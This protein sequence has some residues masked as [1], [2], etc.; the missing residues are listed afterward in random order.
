MTVESA[1][2]QPAAD[3]VEALRAQLKE[4]DRLRRQNQR[5]VA[6]RVEPLAVVG[7]ACRLPGGVESPEDLWDLVRDGRDAISGFPQDRGWDLA[8]LI[9][10]GPGQSITGSGGFLGDVAG[11]DAEFFGIAP[12]EALAMDPQQ[13]ISLEVCWEAL[14]HAGIDPASLAG[15][16]TGVFVGASAGDYDA[17]SDGTEGYNLTGGSMAVVSG[18]LSYQLGLEGPAVTVDTACSSSL[19]ALH[20]AGQ[21]LRQGEC[22]LALVGGVAVLATPGVFV[23]FSRQGGLAPDGRCKSFSETADGTGWAEGAAMLV[24]ERLSD[25]ERNG[26]RVL[27]LVRGSA[28]NQDGA[29]NGLSAPN[30]PSQQRVIR[31]ALKRAGL[32]PSD[33]DVVEAHG[34]GTTLGDPIEAQ[35][36]LATYGQE[37]ERPVLVGSM[38]SNIGHTQA[39]SGL[40]GVIKMVQ[41]LRHGVAP[42]SLHLDQPSSHVD[43]SAGAVELLTG[44]SEWP[45]V[46][47]PRRAAV[48]AFG[49]SGTNAHVILEQG[50]APADHEPAEVPVVPW[51]VSATSE[52]ALATQVDRLRSRTEDRADVGW[53]LL[54]RS[55]FEHRSVLLA[56]EDGVAEVARGVAGE[57]E[58]AFLFS[59]QGSQRLGMGR[60]LYGR[61][62]VFAEAL[63]EVLDR[64]DPA[65]REV[66]WGSDQELLN[67]TGF[68]QPA[69]FAVEVALFRLV[70]SWGVAPDFVAGHSIGEVAAAHVAGVL[71]LDD[72]CT[73][74]RA[75]AGLMEALPSG[76]AMVAIAATEAEVL[77]LLGEGVS[78]A[79]VNGPASV[80]VAGD[81]AAVLKIAARFADRKTTR[82]RA[83]H[84]F[85]SPLMEPMLAEFARALQGLSFAEPRIPLVSN[86][87]GELVTD[88][89]C[90][91]E[92]WVR[93]V[94]E[95]VRFADGLHALSSAG[96]TAF[97]ELGP[98]GVLTGLVEDGVAVP[99]LRR[100]RDEE[101]SLLTALGRL[102][103]NG[104]DVDW[105]GIVP[106]GRLLDLP[107]YA[108][109]RE[110]FWPTGTPAATP[111]Q[112]SAEDLV[113]S[114]SIAERTKAMT[115][116]VR[117]ETAAVLG[118][119]SSDRVATNRAFGD[120]GF[121][122]LMAVELRR[123]LAATTGV[124]L[125]ATAVFDH[126]TP[127]SLA[128]HLA[129]AML[130][131]DTDIDRPHALRAVSA[132]DP[133]AIVGM[134][135]RYPGG[136]SSPE[137]LWQLV[138]DGA[139]GISRFPSDRGW[140]LD[141][142]SGGGSGHSVTGS[143]GFLA[144]IAGFDA[145]FFG[146][147]PR[148]ALAMDPQQRLVL[149]VCWEAVERAGIDPAS[150]RG[151]QSGVFVGTNG[152]DY[153]NLVLTADDD[154]LGHAGTGLAAS[155]MSGRVAYTLGLE[156]PAVTVDTA[157]SSS[158][159]A[160]HWAAHA[161]RRGECSLALAGGVNLMSTSDAFV[162]FSLQGGLAPDGRSKS[163]SDDA[164]G[165]AWSEG[166]GMVL[167]E[168]LSD[169]RR[170]GHHVLALLRG[171]AVNSDGASNGLTAPSGP[172]QRRVIRQA[173]ADARLRSS[174]VDV[175]EAHGT[176]TTLGDPIEA[177]ALLRTYGQERERPLLLGS[178]KSNIGHSQAAA[179]VA[180]L[181][182]MVQAMRHGVV[183]KT[184]HVIAP[185]SAVDWSTGSIE[186][187]TEQTAWPETGRPRR[188]AVSSFGV[189][190]TNAH[191][192]VEHVAAP[193]EP[194]TV[195]PA[196]V[197]WPVSAKSAAALA[198]QIERVRSVDALRT[199]IAWSLAARTA[200]ENRAVLLATDDGVIEV[201]RG[202]VAEQSVAFLFSGQGSQRVGMGRD[203]YGRFPVFAA[204]FDEVLDRLEPGLRD[205][206]WGS[207][208][209]LLNRTGF[210]Q[211]ALFAV[212][213]A[214]FRLVE[215][216]GVA[217]DFVAGHSIGEVAAAHVAGVLSLDDACTLVRAR[218]GLMEALPAGGAM[219]AIAATEAE[220]L[221]LLSEGVSIA[222]VNRADSVV[223]AG[224]EAAVLEIAARFEDRKTSGL[225][226]SH[227]FHSPLMEPMLA[228]FA[229]ALQGLSF[230]APFMPLVSNVTGALVT[231]EVCSPEYWVRHVREAVRFADGLRALTDAGATA[232]LELG[233]DG[234]LTGLVDERPAVAALRRNRDEETSLLTA[235]GELHVRGVDVDWR[236]VVPA[237]RLVDLPTYPFEHERFWPEIDHVVDVDSWRYRVDWL[238]VPTT[239]AE[240]SPG[241]W[242]VIMSEGGDA[243]WVTDVLGDDVDLQ[244]QGDP[245]DPSRSYA[246]V[247]IFPHTVESV[248]LLT[249]AVLA[250]DLDARMWCVTRGAVAV[251]GD[252]L[253]ADAGLSMVWG[254]GRVVALERPATWGGLVDLPAEIDERVVAGLRSVLAGSEDQ[255]AVRPTGVFGRRLVRAPIT[256]GGDWRPRGTALITGGTGGL[257]A[258]VARWLARD[259][260]EHLVLMSRRGPAA[261]GA[262]ELRAELEAL[263]ARVTVVACDAAD[264]DAVS[265]VL[266]AVPADVPL[267]AV[268]HAAGVVAGNAG[269]ES[270]TPADLDG[271]IRAKVTSARWLHELTED[272]ELDAFV[273]F[274]SIA[275]I[276]GTGGQSGYAAANAYLDGLAEYRRG[277]GLPATAVS[278]GAWAEAGMA[279]DPE[280]GDHL[281]KRGVLPIRPDAGLTALR[282]AIEAGDTAVTVSN[283]DWAR[284]VP[285][286]T[287]ARPS[288]L[289]AELPE[290][291][292]ALAVDVSGQDAGLRR[293][294]AG[295][296]EQERRQAVLDLVRTTASAAL[297][298]G[299][300]AEVPPGRAFRDLGFDSLTAVDLRGRLVAATGLPLP[301]TL[302]FDHPTA[303]VLAEYLV[304]ELFGAASAQQAPVE[305]VARV[306]GDPVVVV[307]MACRYPGGVGSA[308]ELWQLVVSG[309]DAIGDFPADRGWRVEPGLSATA[310]GGFLH[311]IAGFDAGFFGISPREAQVM[312]PQQ[313]LLLETSWEALEHAGIDPESVRGSQTGV[314]VGTNGQDYSTLVENASEDVGGMAG[315][316]LAASVLS[317]RVS[318][319]FGFE[320]P[321][322]TI[323]TA[324]SSSLVALHLAAQ[325]LRSGE[326]SLA[327]AGGVTVMSTPDAFVEFTRQGGLA[328]D[329]RCKPFS[330]RADGTGWSEGV[331]VLVVERLS[332]A[333]RNGHPVLAVLRGSAVNQDGASNGLTAPNGPSQQRVIRRALAGAGLSP[334]EVD[335]VEAHGTGTTL[336]DPIEAQALVGVYGQDRDRPLLLGAIKSNLGHTQA[337]A[338][339]AG[340]IKMIMAMRHGVLPATL[341]AD[342]P[343][344]HVDWS[345]GAVRLL[346]ENT[347]WETG[348]RPRR[349]GISSFGISGTNAHVIIEEPGPSA[350][351]DSPDRPVVPWVV[352]AKSETAL[353]AQ[354]GR[355]REVDAPR[356]DVGWSLLAR[357]E[358]DHRAVLLATATGVSEVARGVA[359]KQVPAFLFSGQGSQR[360]GMGRDLA[361]RFPVFSDALDEVLG[362]LPA[363]L[364][365]RMWGSDA[366][367]LNRTGNA[368]P[369]LFAV[370]VALCRLLES[371]GIVPGFVGGHSVGEIAAAHVAG[372]FSL[373][374]ACLLVET[375]A[376]LMQALPP[377]GA[378]VAI[379]A[380][381]AEVLAV[382]PATVAIA[383]VNSRSSVVVAGPEDDVLAV[384][385][386]FQ[387]RRTTRLRVSHAFHSPLVEPVLD[388]FAEVVAGLRFGRP[389]L[390][391][392]SNLTGGLVSDELC[393][394]E[395]WVRHV[396]ETVRFADGLR[397]VTEAG[398]TL[399][400][401]VG[402]GSALAALADDATVVP[403]LRG[404]RDEE[405]AVL[406]AAARAHVAGAPVDWRRVVPTGR[407]VDLP[408]YAF[409]HQ[410]LW[411]ASSTE[412]A[413]HDSLLRL[414]WVPL[415]TGAAEAGRDVEFFRPSI[416]TDVVAGVHDSVRQVLAAVED[417][418]A[419]D[420][421]D[422]AR[423]VVVTTGAVAAGPAEDVTGI[424]AAGVWG[425]VR[426]AQSEH[427]GRLLLV[428]LDGDDRSE[429]VL[430]AA[431]GAAFAAD[432]S[433]LAIREGVVSVPRLSRVHDAP[434]VTGCRD[435]LSGTV[436]VTG[437]T[438]TLG[439]LVAR[440]LVT[441]RGVRRLLLTSRRGPEAPDARRLCAE[442]AE[443]GAEA[444]V[445]ACDMADREAVAR[446]L[447]DIPSEHPLTGVVHAA[448]VVDDGVVGALT[449]EQVDRV[450][451][452]KADSAWFLHELTEH[453]DL[454]LFVLFSS[455]A[456]VLGAQGQANYAAANTFLDAVAQHRR[457][458]GLA[459]TSLAWGLWAE[460]SGIS[461]D[462]TEAGLAR[463]R[464]SGAVA[465]H[466]EQ[467][468]ELFDIGSEM[469]D[470]LVVPAPLDTRV[471]VG[472]DVPAVL[473]DLVPAVP[474]TAD[475][476]RT[477]G[478]SLA[479]RLAGLDPR[480]QDELVLRL[481]SGH[482]ATVLG[483]DS[484][485]QVEPHRG[486][487]ELGITSLTAVELRNLLAAD[488]GIRLPSTLVFDHPAPAVLAGHLRAAV[489]AAAEPAIEPLLARL[490]SAA[491]RLSDEDRESLLRRLTDLQRVLLG[492]TEPH[493][494][495]ALVLADATDDEMF[496]LIDKELGLD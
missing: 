70:E 265:G 147:S 384:A 395:Y 194:E 410:R 113:L 227:A 9:G 430:R 51:V 187:V 41:A 58:L 271:E 210:A 95:A 283:M 419:A 97:L 237:G 204:A 322:M 473:R 287:A 284:F 205:V 300:A 397:A 191:V 223:V 236:Q 161:L 407:R 226:V 34:T 394:P 197:P 456:G 50:P 14:E 130:G 334:S 269:V 480:A 282:R 64:L 66:M 421:Q 249:Q 416:G 190:G 402:P 417:L 309:E 129:S 173:L 196:V 482:V 404:D 393:S 426:S 242:L 174:D 15:S 424:A 139:D 290:V 202:V 401:E 219:V 96:V 306:E 94:R 436:L 48:S 361:A 27:A 132:D 459:A 460:R 411:L 483:L 305:A 356:G 472:A 102:Y 308:E 24:L 21:S 427:P 468:L 310:S 151:S 493:D 378:M 464:R 188:A 289:L 369:A 180:G 484:A 262:D 220:V 259:G 470:A 476:H 319:T 343:S 122:S 230:R 263:G 103:V 111:A 374:D 279:A 321:A 438:G 442:L 146:I 349:A 454:A 360:L 115:K 325:A 481:V 125:A 247:L 73:L 104:V 243:D 74:V 99:A 294:L 181:I 16:Q 260:V 186:L 133:I 341:H 165:V 76:G 381:E 333:E 439:G 352:S 201:A 92:Y 35:A 342:P 471:L 479:E 171:S 222:A 38:K 57:H 431:V 280:V 409:Q 344:S 91:P 11:F 6:A 266:A 8:G 486:F 377:G 462:L 340:V 52:P 256:A 311:D 366:D 327:L 403:V 270:L 229:Q 140:D 67:R 45:E 22:D 359:G 330:D 244:V 465:L 138:A 353:T 406:A 80:V 494:D 257:G 338:G 331:G 68:A 25:A 335:A 375:R 154:V 408:T 5:L 307:G 209:E 166:V 199:D 350:G 79:A 304:E 390:P 153:A 455:A 261:P 370:E 195:D 93:H 90:D 239:N 357:S 398:A 33:V 42:Q 65:V 399:L 285:G 168:R 314:F 189:S 253:V 60:G 371:W 207:D 302:A 376:R 250:A 46:D 141:A 412:T 40:A 474:R 43:W 4:N 449:A 425:L 400:L 110:R 317:G 463:L 385:A 179:G 348:G 175:V 78:I 157:C 53:T 12:R 264:R 2:N 286:Y 105:R 318:Y 117:A 291:A 176:G 268:F 119:T 252:E 354:I 277:R 315:T 373:P 276:W 30:G 200:F 358:F 420:R 39:A 383:A 108:F 150:L 163:F 364:R 26:H 303:E 461:G 332:D 274:S 213:V 143:G 346:S 339:V 297:G 212:E 491:P 44:P 215:S 87:T 32:T 75:R 137:D 452:A 211:P 101:T 72:A 329:G 107:T 440:H 169:A 320:G 47:R 1:M 233:P 295:L 388:D 238:P 126:P 178:I 323:D 232:F 367:E 192:I 443:L 312:D 241:R 37:R 144:D 418:L 85:H 121:D 450:L 475:E 453:L 152:Q 389:S 112:V 135:C 351:Q 7:M 100:D 225:K 13:R 422:G 28:V 492:G 185:S 77:P 177:H 336:G 158:L 447:A 31:S 134:A 55:V 106:A 83:S 457:A 429:A 496:A 368:Q 63:D 224:D 193:V 337:A 485:D 81:E 54:S 326:C 435:D 203:L 240:V 488:T 84:A 478:P 469:P 98:D 71:S 184:L 235:L 216:W 155:V 217:P 23:E 17:A 298:R 324:C 267:T 218:A 20:W 127:S 145:R 109:Q 487:L 423:L 490:E 86:V 415:S 10:T 234:V 272:A 19:V 59:G 61:F 467:A 301:T 251:D 258:F 448:G 159:V 292:A 278:W 56:S 136:I 433:Q 246:G 365:E 299:D 313:R 255:V 446:L 29:S 231:D 18:R 142:L 118:H 380:T 345:A 466:T 160:L 123:R 156:G 405:T 444:H 3:F 413:G 128:A 254:L 386:R 414:R 116:V 288:P 451:R 82:L 149:E 164:D 167:L 441:R 162:G 495:Q 387:G 248:L 275:G 208:Q 363:G 458:R 49:V 432:E 355:L 445:V 434:V 437:G 148:E 328:P 347:P 316:G 69:L 382:L 182:K 396:R 372:V 198:A 131:Q 362:Y 391:V 120:L 489:D 214:L 428:D 124:E 281:R 296:P 170:H 36:L 88:E 392:V 293:T 172:A 62:P 228:E 89:V 379:A 221:P 183:P 245:I 114:G 477:A 206:M 273:L